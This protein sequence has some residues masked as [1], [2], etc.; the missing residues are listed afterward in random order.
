MSARDR[1]ET[2]RPRN[3]RV[4]DELGRPLAR[5]ADG[6][7]EP[8]PVASSPEQT[9]EDAQQL[10]DSG[11]AFR[12][13]EVLEAMWKAVDGHDRELWRGLAQLAVGIT[14][15]QRGNQQGASALLRRSAQTLAAYAG[16]RPFDIDVDGLRH[17]A[18]NAASD[19][20]KLRVTP[21]LRGTR[22][23]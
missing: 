7:V 3:A 14:H 1:D 2:G 22:Q 5:D 11:R 17:W 9:L 4:R 19:P 12:A 13:H 6:L 21:Q 20:S 16:G 23:A 10:L 18:T 8:D 15:A